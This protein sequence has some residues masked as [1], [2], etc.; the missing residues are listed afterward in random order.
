M[1]EHDIP[2]LEIPESVKAALSNWVQ[3]AAQ[4]A[5]SPCAARSKNCV[6]N[7]QPPTPRWKKTK[8]RSRA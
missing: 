1:A 3:Q 4:E 8:T 7:W 6:R 5:G 2:Q